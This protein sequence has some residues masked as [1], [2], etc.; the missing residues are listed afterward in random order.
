[1]HKELHYTFYKGIIF[2][3]FQNLKIHI[4]FLKFS[5]D[6]LPTI[7]G[8]SI[9]WNPSEILRISL[10]GIKHFQVFKNLRNPLGVLK[11]SKDLLPTINGKSINW[12]PTGYATHLPSGDKT[13]W[14][15]KKFENPFR[16]FV[17]IHF[18]RNFYFPPK[19]D[20]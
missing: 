11:C 17:S 12:T 1:M 3:R 15:K 7:N 9:N 20:A 19:G 16:F 10:R 14:S 18:S 13:F 8:K 2:S 6:L 5:E 4:R